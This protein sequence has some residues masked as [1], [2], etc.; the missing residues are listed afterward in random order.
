MWHRNESSSAVMGGGK[1]SWAIVDTIIYGTA[2]PRRRPLR[3]RVAFTVRHSHMNHFW[4]S[5]IVTAGQLYMAAPSD[6]YENV[7]LW[8]S[9]CV[10]TPG[11]G[12]GGPMVLVAPCAT[13]H[14]FPLARWCS[15]WHCCGLSARGPASQRT[16]SEDR[17][18]WRAVEPVSG[19]D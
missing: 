4:P 2:D 16:F 10:C 7:W 9:G 3:Q 12:N 1:N 11:G 14:P 18:W 8:L 19:P 13:H 15:T 5:N 6:S 17:R